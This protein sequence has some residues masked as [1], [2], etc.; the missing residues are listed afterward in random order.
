MVLA[1]IILFRR[2]VLASGSVLSA[3]LLK[4]EFWGITRKIDNEP[5]PDGLPEDGVC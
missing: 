5:L 1:R 4:F 3:L 2:P